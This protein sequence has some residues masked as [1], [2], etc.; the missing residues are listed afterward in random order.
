MELSKLRERQC[1]RYT[2]HR[3]KRVKS[4]HGT[5][6]SRKLLRSLDHVPLDFTGLGELIPNMQANPGT[7]NT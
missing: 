4:E 6:K 2:D 1:A 7:Q 5:T 3:T